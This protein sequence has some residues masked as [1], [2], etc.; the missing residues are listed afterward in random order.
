MYY[1]IT[2]VKLNN[3]EILN[4]KNIKEDCFPIYATLSGITPPSL[5]D[6]DMFVYKDI[7]SGLKIYHCNQRTRLEDKFLYYSNVQKVSNLE[8]EEYLTNLPKIFYDYLNC[9]NDFKKQVIKEQITFK[10]KS[11]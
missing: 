4:F 11:G 10:K 8:V 5:T 7:I 6:E 2:L 1:K 3:E 9:L